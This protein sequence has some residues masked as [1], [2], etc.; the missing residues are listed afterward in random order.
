[1]PAEILTFHHDLLQATYSVQH[2]GILNVIP[3]EGVIQDICALN[4]ITTQQ[5]TATI[6]M[7]KAP[8]KCPIEKVLNTVLL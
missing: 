3:I 1:M 5:C 2:K 4:T 7:Q 8:C 6:N